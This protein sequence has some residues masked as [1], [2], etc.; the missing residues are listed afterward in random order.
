MTRGV[1]IAAFIHAKSASSML[2][3]LDSA[4]L[5]ALVRAIGADSPPSAILMF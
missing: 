4:S 2:P 5:H 3:L 1:S